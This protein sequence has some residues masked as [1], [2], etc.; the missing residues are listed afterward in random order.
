M[1]AAP[2][3]LPRFRPGRWGILDAASL[4]TWSRILLYSFGGGPTPSE[5]S[6]TWKLLMQYAAS[7]ATEDMNRSGPEGLTAYRYMG[8]AA[9]ASV[10]V[11][12]SF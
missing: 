3:N 6:A 5:W 10:K 1:Y 9:R 11:E 12:L 8:D 7:F 4:A 2:L